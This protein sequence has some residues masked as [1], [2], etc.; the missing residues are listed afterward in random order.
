MQTFGCESDESWCDSFDR[1]PVAGD[2]LLLA[3]PTNSGAAA[4]AT[5][6][7]AIATKSADATNSAGAGATEVSE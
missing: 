4:G 5:N 3:G 7:T 1:Q 6:Y 2:E